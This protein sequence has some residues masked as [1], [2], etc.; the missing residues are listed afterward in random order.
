MSALPQELDTTPEELEE[1]PD[2]EQDALQ[3]AEE[4]GENLPVDPNENLRLDMAQQLLRRYWGISFAI[5]RAKKVAQG[6]IERLKKRIGATQ[7]WEEAQTAPLLQQRKWVELQLRAIGETQ[8]ATHP[9]GPQFVDLPSGR[10]SFAKP[11]LSCKVEEVDRAV[12]ALKEA[13]LTDLI[14]RTE[15]ITEK[16]DLTTLKKLAAKPNVMDPHADCTVVVKYTDRETGE[17]VELTVPG[18]KWEFEP[19]Y[20]MK[21]ERP[22][23]KMP[24]P[25]RADA[26]AARAEEGGAE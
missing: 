4:A 21:V 2:P 7:E 26:R 24:E 22:V 3:L 25:E 16:P 17:V 18:L 23:T 1:L 13:G 15:V 20:K 6:E 12:E 14:A 10:I 9:K 5:E 11:S 19:G 8:L